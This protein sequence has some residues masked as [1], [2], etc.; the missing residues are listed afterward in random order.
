MEKKT[1]KE[2][3]MLVRVSGNYNEKWMYMV[4]HH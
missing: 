4:I 1:T 3:L 2:T